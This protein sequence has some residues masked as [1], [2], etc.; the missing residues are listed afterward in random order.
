M[1]CPSREGVGGADSH[2]QDH[3]LRLLV[4][5]SVTTPVGLVG[6]SDLTPGTRLEPP[7]LYSTSIL[8][9]GAI[10]WHKNRN[11]YI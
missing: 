3:D 10:L 2:K 9:F 1:H 7:L 6:S 11:A 4:R 8:D 5:H